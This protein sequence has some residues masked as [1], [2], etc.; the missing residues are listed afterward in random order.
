MT[1]GSPLSP[2]L[3]NIYMEYFEEID[4]GS[5]PLKPL[6]WLRYVDEEWVCT[7]SMFHCFF[8]TLFKITYNNNVN[9]DNNTI[10]KQQ[11]TNSFV[12]K[13]LWVLP[14]TVFER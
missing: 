9:A 5:S 8:L 7:V 14:L 6:M 2:V 3:V 10:Q 12:S 1:M 13:K 11:Y 4:I